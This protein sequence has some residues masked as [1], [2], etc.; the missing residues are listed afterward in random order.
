MRTTLVFPPSLCLPNPIYF[1]LPLL[2]GALKR[3]GH[4]THIVD[5]NALAADRFLTKDWAA[6]VLE[7]ARRI[8]AR[9]SAGGGGIKELLART[10]PKLLDGPSCKDT[11]RDPVRNFVPEAFKHAFST[12]IEVLDFFYIEDPV[13]SPHRD[14]FGR[15][16][17]DHVT[18]DP[19]SPLRD[20]YEEVLLDEVFSRDPELI[21]I[22]T[23][24]PE[25]AAE[26]VRLAAKLRGRKR[27]VHICFGGPLVSLFPDK[28]LD[29]GWLL[30][31]ADSVVVGDG[32]TAVVELAEWIEGKRSREE[33]RNLVYPDQGGGARWNSKELYFESMDELPLPD[34]EPAD[35]SLYL[36]PRPI[37]PLMLSRGCYWAK[38]AFCSIG[39]H[40]HYRK[41][42][43]ET[44]R[45]HVMDLSQKY[46][47]R[48]IMLQDSSVPPRG[49]RELAR[50]VREERLP[51]YWMGAMKF[52]HAFLDKN[53]CKEIAEGGCR[54]LLLGFESANQ[55]VL[56]LMGKGFQLKDVPTMLIN[57][58]EAGTSAELLWFLGFPTEDREDVLRTAQYLMDHRRLFGL[59]SFVGDYQLHPDTAIYERPE[60]F[61]VTILGEENGKCIYVM[62][63]GMQME[64]K[65]LLKRLFTTTENRNLACNGAHLPHLVEKGLD[66]SGIEHPMRIPPE[67]IEFCGRKGE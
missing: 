11:L 44:V 35:L 52:E 67:V 36:T 32:E 61:G 54:S 46:D 60:D 14:D 26:S 21:G 15:D 5:L 27:D 9:Q 19:W 25:Q 64:E 33:V 38:C 22:S 42:S 31:Y 20:L 4:E 28:W 62:A 65:D 66:L 53:Y 58:K 16:V 47:A 18:K 39:W 63:T 48:Y 29:E 8:V 49:A 59:A 51:V 55:R 45:T 1:S 56:D 40:G 37:Y 34:F 17:I 3:A 10:E 30:Q 50:I 24:F 57:L 6:R 7:H 41:A 23:A 43:T 13:I 2:A 12:V